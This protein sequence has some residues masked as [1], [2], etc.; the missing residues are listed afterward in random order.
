[1]IE[2]NN[3]PIGTTVKV[4]VTP[5]NGARTEV[6]SSPLAGSQAS[7]SATASLTLPQGFCLL[8]ASA[9]VDLTSARAAPLYLDG[10]RVRLME[11]VASLGGQSV[12]TYVTES[13][14]RISR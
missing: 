1:M 3:I 7:S 4:S 10:E 9:T 14:R 11:V 5:P 13:G 12:V 6:T 8:Q 2:A